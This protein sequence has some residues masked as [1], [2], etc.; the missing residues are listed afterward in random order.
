MQAHESR[1]QPNED[2]QGPRQHLHISRLQRR[3]LTCNDDNDN[4]YNDYDYDYNDNDNDYYDYNYDNDNDSTPSL[5]PP[6]T[7]PP[8]LSRNPPQSLQ[9]GTATSVDARPP[10]ATSFGGPFP[11]LGAS[12]DLMDELRIGK[13]NWWGLSGEVSEGLLIEGGDESVV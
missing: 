7:P 11:G 1:R 8:S 4:D 2:T 12:E 13:G 6:P 9:P 5:P 3:N 10:V